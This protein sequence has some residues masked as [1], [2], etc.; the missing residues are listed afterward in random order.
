VD[1]HRNSAEARSIAFWPRIR[2]TRIP[3]DRTSQPFDLDQLS[4]GQHDFERMVANAE[5]GSQ[6]RNA[7]PC[8]YWTS[9]APPHFPSCKDNGFSSAARSQRVKGARPGCAQRRKKP[10][11]LRVYR[12]PFTA[13]MAAHAGRR[14]KGG[15]R[16]W[17]WQ[18]RVAS[19]G[20]GPSALG[21]R[22]PAPSTGNLP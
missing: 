8:P 10:E 11:S 1:E 14:G 4:G 9:F 12:R 5:V 20:L 19:T 2:R 6:A 7:A 16:F 15:R 21:V 22:N 3:V 13:R 17:E 18:V